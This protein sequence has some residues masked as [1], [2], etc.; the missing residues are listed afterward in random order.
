MVEW[1]YS[2][3]VYRED[4][5]FV[6]RW[7]D[8]TS[9]VFCPRAN[10]AHYAGLAKSIWKGMTDSGV[11]TAKKYLYAL[12][13]VL[14]AEHVLRNGAPAPVRFG[15][16]LDAAELSSGLRSEIQEMIAKKACGA[17]SDG[18]G[19]MVAVD[20]FLAEA[21]QSMAEGVDSMESRVSSIDCLDALFRSA[22]E[23]ER[24]APD[25]GATPRLPV[26]RIR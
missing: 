19:R 1:L 7:R 24:L 9:E 17:E 25:G 11:V 3:I 10:A 5:A 21:L 15:E 20:G 8:L 23:Q 26:A 2:P 22:L 13:A 14:A 6:G 4:E 16:L 18:V 12:R